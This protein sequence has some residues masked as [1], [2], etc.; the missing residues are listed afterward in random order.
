M[1]WKPELDELAR[2]KRG[3]LEKLQVARTSDDNLAATL[4]ETLYLNRTM[5]WYAELE[6]KLKAVTPESLQ[7]A[8]K[9]H[10][11]PKRLVIV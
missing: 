2:A 1:S 5:A 7:A 9:K 11:Q 4:D 3:Y 6:T 10:V 8:M